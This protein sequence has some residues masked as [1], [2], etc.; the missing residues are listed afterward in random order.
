MTKNDNCPNCDAPLQASAPSDASP[1]CPP[2][3]GNQNA[4]GGA[5]AFREG[6]GLRNEHGD[7][8]T[9]RSERSRLALWGLLLP[10]LAVGLSIPAALLMALIRE[11]GG[12]G[13]WRYLAAAVPTLAVLAV[14]TGVV[15]SIVALVQIRRSNG[16]LHGRWM[17]VAGVLVPMLFCV[18]AGGIACLTVRTTPVQE[19]DSGSLE[20]VEEDGATGRTRRLGFSAEAPVELQVP[21]ETRA[22]TPAQIDP[23]GHESDGAERAHEGD[24]NAA[25]TEANRDSAARRSYSAEV[26]PG[27]GSPSMTQSEYALVW[28]TEPP[29]TTDSARRLRSSGGKPSTT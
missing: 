11:A 19:T 1:A 10:I 12:G 28:T 5:T 25:G 18:P 2:T 7:M 16:R 20:R 17:A 3:A 9:T 26:V 15:L 22:G 4:D 6:P 21:A 29:S 24:G 27:T 23:H 13:A 14:L 8:T